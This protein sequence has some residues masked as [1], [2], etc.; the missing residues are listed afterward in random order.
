MW[1]VCIFLRLTTCYWTIILCAPSLT[2]LWRQALVSHTCA[3]GPHSLELS[4]LLPP[5]QVVLVSN[6]PG[7]QAKASA[8]WSIVLLAA[9]LDLALFYPY[10][11]I[12]FT[13]EWGTV[14]P[15]QKA[16]EKGKVLDKWVFKKIILG[17][18]KNRTVNSIRQNK[19]QTEGRRL[20]LT[21]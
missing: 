20:G 21:Q 1:L 19:N 18:F 15:Q 2:A 13:F 17:S 5:D 12:E 14:S 10:T 11:K 9:H 4:R 3:Q 6:P 8:E 7:Q 16:V